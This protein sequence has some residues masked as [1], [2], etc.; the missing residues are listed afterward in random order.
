LGCVRYIGVFLLLP[1]IAFPAMFYGVGWA[2]GI[3]NYIGQ[4]HETD[5]FKLLALTPGG[6]FGANWGLAMGYLYRHI[7]FRNINM[8]KNLL[9]RT[10]LVALPF[11]LLLLWSLPLATY[12]L[13]LLLVGL[14]ID[15]IQA[16]ALT[17][18][19]GILG[20]TFQPNAVNAQMFA[21]TLYIGT[22]ITTWL[23]QFAL[24]ALM[25]AIIGDMAG[26]WSVI[27]FFG[28]HF[29]VYITVRELALILLWR[30]LKSRLE[31][32]LVLE[33]VRPPLSPALEA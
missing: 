20:P 14:W 1:V 23:I 19:C 29:V 9:L 22:L 2:T 6:A 30:I 15:H 33:A 18:L 27:W 8:V 26:D 16:T 10:A 3:A 32:A 7:T 11:L 5:R 4:E 28:I 13:V 24:N 17:L 25:P 21:F 31:D 12:G